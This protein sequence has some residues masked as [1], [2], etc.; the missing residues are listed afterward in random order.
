VSRAGLVPVM[1][2]AQRAATSRMREWKRP[3]SVHWPAGVNWPVIAA[4]STGS[5]DLPA[6]VSVS[7]S[8]TIQVVAVKAGW[9]SMLPI[10]FLP[11]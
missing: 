9:F 5:G 7:K 10:V 4:T 3:V 6:G 1:A 11:W 2:L 8:M